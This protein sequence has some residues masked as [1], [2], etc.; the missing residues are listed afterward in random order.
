MLCMNEKVP[1]FVILL[2]WLVWK[3]SRNVNWAANLE[4]ITVTHL[5][6]GSKQRDERNKERKREKRGGKIGENRNKKEE[7]NSKNK[8][9][10]K[11]REKRNKATKETREK[12]NKLHC[13]MFRVIFLFQA[14]M[15]EILHQSTLRPLIKRNCK[16]KSPGISGAVFRQERPQ[17]A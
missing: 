16:G 2:T 1:R 12:R 11:G 4:T 9:E 14:R 5:T 15:L 10:Y 13:T 17:V 7:K 3:S 8:N 6:D